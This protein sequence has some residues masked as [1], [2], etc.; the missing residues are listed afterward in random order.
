MNVLDDEEV[1]PLNLKNEYRQREVTMSEEDKNQNGKR[2]TKTNLTG[3]K[4][5]NLSK[6]KAQI[7]RL[8]KVLEGAL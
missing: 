6:K 2:I 1:F 3:K 7:K 4:D 8:Q 5:R